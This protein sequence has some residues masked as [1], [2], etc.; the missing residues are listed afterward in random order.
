MMGSS[1]LGAAHGVSL[2][3]P[4]HLCSIATALAL[5]AVASCKSG[6]LECTVK[7]EGV[8]PGGEGGVVVYWYGMVS[9]SFLS[10]TRGWRSSL[11]SFKM[12]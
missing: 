4:A 10:R 2:V 8:K 3:W 1:S 12:L 11:A 7:L 9:A 5:P 6:G